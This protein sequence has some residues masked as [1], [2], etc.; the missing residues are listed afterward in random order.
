MLNTTFIVALAVV[1][2]VGYL[3]GSI[4]SAIIVSHFYAGE[5]V[6]NHGSGNAGMTNMLRTYGKGPAVL[7]AAGDFLK[8]VAAILLGRLV[9]HLTGVSATGFP[10][11]A[12]YLAG[13][14]V[15][16]GH[17]FPVYFKFKGGKGVMSTLG[18]IFMTNPIG[19]LILA[20]V[21]VPLAF[22]TRIV[23][24]GSVLGAAAYPIVTWLVRHFQ[25]REPLYDTL[26]A[27]VIALLIIYMHR[28]NIRRLLNGTENKFSRGPKEQK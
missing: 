12:G 27:A 6:R 14:F 4:N 15:L 24:L 5:D 9:F 2:L 16:L 10:L 19:F 28:E 1:A 25:G 17:M 8:A 11:D 26:C 21:F 20:A 18:V 22:L 3:L 23:S 13:L 7:T